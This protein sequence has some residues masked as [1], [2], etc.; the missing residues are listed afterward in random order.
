[1]ENKTSKYFKYAIGE[2]ALVM[3]GILLALQVN[4]WNESRKQ[5]QTIE[6]LT[7][8]FESELEA[9]IQTCSS[10]MRVGY[11]RDSICTLYVNGQLS[12]EQLSNR[13]VMWQLGFGTSTRRFIDDN[14]DELIATEKQLPSAYKPLTPELK[15]L[16]RRIE[17]QRKCEQIAIDISISS[18]TEMANRYP[19][20]NL[21]DSLSGE[22]YIDHILTDPIYK[23]KLLHYNAYQL[24]ENTW[25]A[26]IIRTSSVALLWK[27]KQIKR[28]APPTIEEFLDQLGLRSFQKMDCDGYP[29]EVTEEI[30]LYSNFIFYNNRSDT[31]YFNFR[32][33]EGEIFNE[34]LS[35]PPHSFQLDEW[36]FGN[37]EC[38]E[39][40]QND[41][42]H[43]VYR[44]SKEDYLIF[45]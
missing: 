12:R 26:T 34:K 41:S 29:F 4:N 33:S 1:M 10:L 23:S 35:L 13:R 42:C 22:S 27:L 11:R 5:A 30:N 17:S 3:I 18:R 21:S 14:L 36:A 25:D 9:N 19:W 16:K 2:I 38:I 15:E 40:L 28:T 31:V 20:Y 37:D 43:A 6:R 39:M 24:D 44:R 8:V 45:N 7:D 32:N